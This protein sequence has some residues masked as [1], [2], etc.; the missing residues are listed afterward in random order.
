MSRSVPALQKSA[1]VR[2]NARVA[3]SSGSIRRRPEDVLHGAIANSFAHPKV[4]PRSSDAKVQFLSLRMTQIHSILAGLVLFL[5]QS[6]TAGAPA[7]FS[8][9]GDWDVL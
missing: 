2:V 5:A 3:S 6:A 9:V 1:S 8:L 4:S 7:N